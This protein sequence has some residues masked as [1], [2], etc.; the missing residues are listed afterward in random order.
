VAL[1][2]GCDNLLSLPHLL[3]RRTNG[4]EPLMDYFQ[5]HVVTLEE[6]LKIMR[7]KAM[8]REATKQIRESKRK[9][10]F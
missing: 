4:R 10:R 1:V 6:Y 2:Q 5:N 8:D 7:Q 3:I 9:E